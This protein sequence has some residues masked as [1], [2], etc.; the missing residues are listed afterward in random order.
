MKMILSLACAALALTALPAA[1]QTFPDPEA[2]ARMQARGEAYS[3]AED[4][5]QDPAELE[6]TRLLNAE[7]AARNRAAEEREAADNAAYA[8]TLEA[9]AVAEEAY[10]RDVAAAET[11]RANHQAAV[12]AA[13]AARMAWEADRAA[14]LADCRARHNASVCVVPD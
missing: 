1:A 7:I 12:S 14:W 2:D 5:E 11:A 10:R 13:D 8:A 4:S 3:R 6:R 9:S